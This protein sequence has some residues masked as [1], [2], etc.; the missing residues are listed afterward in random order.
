MT[1]WFLLKVIHKCTE[2]RRLSL[3]L[4][5]VGLLQSIVPQRLG[6]FCAPPSC[7]YVQ[8]CVDVGLRR[9]YAPRRGG[10]QCTPL[11]L[12]FTRMFSRRRRISWL[13]LLLWD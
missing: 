5:F 2:L 6:V 4:G 10:S 3:W 8:S 1:F 11:R 7:A 13:L 9:S 12:V